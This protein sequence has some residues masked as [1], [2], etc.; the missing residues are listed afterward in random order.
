MKTKKAILTL[1][2]VFS[3][4]V[5]FSAGAYAGKII[6]PWR[7]KKEIVKQGKSF[8]IWFKKGTTET[9]NSISLVG[10]YNKVQLKIKQ[11]KMGLWYYDEYTK[12][13]YNSKLTVKVPKGTPEELYDLVVETSTGTYNSRSAVKVIPKFLNHYY[14]CNFTD[15]HV[16]VSWNESGNATAPIM[17]ALGEIITVIDPALA[18]CTGDNIIGFSRTPVIPKDFSE[19]WD[20]F[21]DGTTPDGLGGMHNARVPLYITTG[22]NDYDKYRE[23]PDAEKMYKLTDWNEFCGMRVFGFAYDHTRFLAFD[24]YL[25]ELK[26]HGR[27][28]GTSK[29]FPAIQRTVLEKYLKEEGAGKLRIVLQHAPNRVD[30]VFCNKN[31]VKLALCGHTHVD[32]LTVIGTTPTKVYETAYVCFAEYWS[33]AYAPP[34]KSGMTKLRIIEI[35]DN[36]IASN[37]SVDIMDYIQVMKG[38]SDGKFLNTSYDKPNNGKNNFNTAT[39]KNKIDYNFTACKIRF[40]MPKGKYSIDNGTLLQSFS[41]DTVSVYD[42]KIPVAASSSVSVTIKPK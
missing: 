26:D 34:A 4:N 9:I 16:G 31:R 21:W 20:A 3:A 30:T 37:Q 14:I 24:D 17:Q 36:E 32:N 12:A 42:V 35:K 40:V 5:F 10:P 1:V 2:I 29:D 11:N 15:P 27:F 19:R 18:V 23:N 39:L 22:N 13:T 8:E 33:P 7:A 41:N 28:S 25:G 38:N 6:V